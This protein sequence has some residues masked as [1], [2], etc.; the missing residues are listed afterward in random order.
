MVDREA[1]RQV[2]SEYFHFPC[3]TFI[4]LITPQS[5]LSII[6][7]W[8]NKPTSGHSNSRRVSTPAPQINKE[9]ITIFWVFYHIL[10]MTANSSSCIPYRTISEDF[11]CFLLYSITLPLLPW[12][13]IHHYHIIYTI[14]LLSGSYCCSCP[15]EEI[16]GMDPK[17]Y[18]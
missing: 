3:H 1:L 10:T 5:F 16:R 18:M 17:P 4:P 11:L 6:H 15:S 2:F 8:F 13:H 12:S 14:L 7:G 9:V